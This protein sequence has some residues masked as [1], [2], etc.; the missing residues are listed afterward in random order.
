MTESTKSQN[1]RRPEKPSSLWTTTLLRQGL[2]LSIN[3][4]PD[5][6]FAA[7]PRKRTPRMQAI[8]AAQTGHC[9]SGHFARMARTDWSC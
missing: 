4:E 7:R 1:V 8:A 9:D 2:A 5:M 6:R 3:Q